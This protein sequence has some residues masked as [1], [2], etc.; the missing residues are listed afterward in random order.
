MQ[1][2]FEFGFSEKK[3]ISVEIDGKTYYFRALFS[4][5]DYYFVVDERDYSEVSYK[6]IVAK[7]VLNH[8]LPR[9]GELSFGKLPPELLNNYIMEILGSSE[10]L[11][12]V[13]NKKDSV[14]DVYERFILSIIEY[15]DI[16]N[17]ELR[18]IVLSSQLFPNE[19]FQQIS[20]L[21]ISKELFNIQP[22]IINTKHINDNLKSIAELFN[23]YARQNIIKITESIQP[24]IQMQQSYVSQITEVVAQLISKCPSISISE[25]KSENKRQA[26]NQWGQY[27]WTI[28]GKAPVKIFYS[29]PAS[30]KE[31]NTI[32]SK[33][34]DQNYMWEII[35]NTKSFNTV[36]HS[37]YNEAVEDYQ[38]K[39]YKSCALILFSLIDARLIRMQT[40]EMQGK[41]AWREVGK[42][43]I[44]LSKQI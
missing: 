28:I 38:N 29:M 22:L 21:K 43:A 2:Q 41:H 19:L 30:L 8:E 26:L 18:D 12:S 3:T 33:Y 15:Y 17:S 14:T 25:D 36:K 23:S 44:S 31:A 10:R 39:R 13:Y 20:G 40:C 11:Q 6:E 7:V 1:N 5:S 32:A 34:C 16:K 9:T 4:I 27:G 24:I 42:N 35:E 37:D